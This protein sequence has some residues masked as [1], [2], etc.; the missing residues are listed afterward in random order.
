VVARARQRGFLSPASS[1]FSAVL[2]AAACAALGQVEALWRA[3]AAIMILVCWPLALLIPAVQR[4]EIERVTYMSAAKRCL[5]LLVP[6]FASA[7]FGGLSSSFPSLALT[8]AVAG[9]LMVAF[10]TA[11]HGLIASRAPWALLAAAVAGAMGL[12]VGGFPSLVGC[13][14]FATFG[15]GSVLFVSSITGDRTIAEGDSA[16]R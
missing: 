11:Q 12:T 14:S 7:T 9:C 3:T 6:C 16:A 4:R 15:A 8:V 5:V 1:A 13:A 10:A 2:A